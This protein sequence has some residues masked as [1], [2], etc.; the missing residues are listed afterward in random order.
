MNMPMIDSNHASYINPF[1]SYGFQRFFAAPEQSHI[2]QDFLNA[3]LAEQYGEITRLEHLHNHILAEKISQHATAANP[4]I[5]DIYCYT[6]TEKKF[7]VQLQVLA[8][9]CFKD[10]SLYY[11]AFALQEQ[12]RRSPSW[13]PAADICIVGLCDFSFDEARPERYHYKLKFADTSSQQIF[14][15]EV[16]F[17]H[18]VLPKFAKKL[19][20]LEHKLDH[21]LYLLQCLQTGNPV[22]PSLQTG[23][24]SEL[25]AILALEPRS[26]QEKSRYA[27][28]LK[29]Y[30]HMHAHS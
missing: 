12:V 26:S 27:Q 14:H 13:E 28:S 23:I 24:F 17:C 6:A 19:E 7:A 1:T 8:P 16:S 18:L 5:V 22:P 30:H 11:M 29:D 15:D 20:Q 25:L 2:L 21:W 4:T 10:Q 3:F 9:Q